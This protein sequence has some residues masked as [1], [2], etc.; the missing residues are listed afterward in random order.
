[1]PI[2]HK[3]LWPYKISDKFEVVIFVTY[4]LPNCHLF[5]LHYCVQYFGLCLHESKI[6]Q[7]RSPLRTH[8]KKSIIA[9]CIFVLQM[10]NF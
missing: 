1:M 7:P 3:I 9:L 10:P 6:T 4:H 2:Y 8:S 5:F